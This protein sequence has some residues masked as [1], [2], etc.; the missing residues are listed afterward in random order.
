[1]KLLQLTSDWK[2]TGPAE[3]M[4]HAVTGLRARGHE[5]DVAFP[6]TPASHSGALAERARERGLSPAYQPAA[7]QGYLPLRDGGEVRRLRAF[8][9]EREYDVV[10]ATHARAQL[11][12]RFALGARRERTKL[13]ASWT[14]GDPIPRRPWNR[15]LY[16]PSGCDGIAVLTERLAAE[17]RA[18]LGGTPERIG[19]IPGVVDTERFAPRPRRADL[20]ESLGLKPDHRVIGLIARLQPHR[21]VD[22]ILEALVRAL[23]EAPSLRLLVV[24]RGTRAR[25]VLDEPVRRLGL[26]HA[27]VRA[28]YLR[29]DEY[30]DVLAQMD[31]LV[32]LVPGSDGSCRAALEA[33]AMGIPVIASRRGILP[34]L[35]GDGAGRTTD[36]HVEQLGAAFV[37]IEREPGHLRERGD[38]AR[39]NALERFAIAVQAERLE[40][41]YTAVSRGR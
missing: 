41:S 16:G 2:W 23:R 11:L 26:E 1:M 29:G 8:L 6:E 34:E 17:T 12:A 25:E 39:R 33:M 19:V 40:R 9:R 15:W 35:L 5:V 3:P 31:A 10:H 24:G 30:L 14:H 38:V 18:F 32:Y 37:E 20:R 28:G 36:E 4:L 27:V 22:L 13:V 21:R 7:G